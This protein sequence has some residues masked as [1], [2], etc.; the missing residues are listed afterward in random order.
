MDRLSPFVATGRVSVLCSNNIIRGG[1]LR[2][3]SRKECWARLGAAKTS[4][5]KCY[6]TCQRRFVWVQQLLSMIACF[7]THYAAS[8]HGNSGVWA[9]LAHLHIN[10]WFW[11]NNLTYLYEQYDEYTQ[12]HKW[13]WGAKVLPFPWAFRPGQKDVDTNLR[14]P[15]RKECKILYVFGNSVCPTRVQSTDRYRL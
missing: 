3:P 8:L 6:K 10:L 14:T 9:S 13:S 4:R 12:D 7:A 15:P 1:D 5:G 2:S 11:N